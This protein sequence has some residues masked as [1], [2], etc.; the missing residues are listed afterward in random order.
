MEKLILVAKW[1]NF[2]IDF[3]QKINLAVEGTT[4]FLMNYCLLNKIVKSAKF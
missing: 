2:Q 3:F 1:E 4:P